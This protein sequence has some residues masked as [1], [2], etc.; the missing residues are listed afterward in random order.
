MDA[1]NSGVVAV[2]A[3]FLLLR[4]EKEASFSAPSVQ[5]DNTDEVKGKEEETSELHDDER[6]KEEAEEGGDLQPAAASASSS[7]AAS[8]RKR[9][10]G[11]ESSK[12]QPSLRLCPFINR[13]EVCST[14]N[15]VY[16]HDAAAFLASKPSDL[17]PICPN[18]A[19]YGFCVNGTLSV[20]LFF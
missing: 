19:T 11:M 3:E 4:S 7:A 6:G 2:K 18:F 12:P 13:S 15:C 20:N 8:K 5:E 16:Q 10:K 9:G 14:L 17:G 1:P